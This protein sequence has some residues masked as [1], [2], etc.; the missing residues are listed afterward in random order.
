[1]KMRM[2]GEG[3]DSVNSNEVTACMQVMNTQTHTQLTIVVADDDLSAAFLRSQLRWLRCAHYWW[4]V[5]EH[6]KGKDLISLKDRVIQD[7]NDHWLFFFVGKEIHL[8]S[9]QDEVLVFFSCSHHRR[10]GRGRRRGRGEKGR[11]E[12]GRGGEGRGGERR[13]GE[14]RGGERRGGER[15]G[16]ERRGE[17]G[18]GGEGR[19]AM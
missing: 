18:R 3:D 6:Q 12:E 8:R 1:M 4:L 16:G 14:R 17:E 13:G 19:K 9:Q 10:G 15:R 7:E 5:V 11:G 2:R